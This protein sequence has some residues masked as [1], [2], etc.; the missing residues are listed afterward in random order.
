MSRVTVL[1]CTEP[2]DRW[3][4][5]CKDRGFSWDVLLGCWWLEDFE[6]CCGHHVALAVSLV[7]SGVLGPFGRI[8]GISF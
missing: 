8:G 4:H 6:S 5:W 3:W 1:R 2:L 7:S